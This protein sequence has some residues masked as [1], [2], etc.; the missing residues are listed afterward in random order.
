MAS[1]RG[2]HSARLRGRHSGTAGWRLG[3]LAVIALLVV[4]LPSTAATAIA[5]T[6]P[7]SYTNPLRPQTAEGAAVD[8]CPDPSVIRGRGAHAGRWFMYCTNASLPAGDGSAR[9]TLVSL[10]M[11]ASRDMVSWRSEGAAISRPSWAAPETYLWAPDIVYSRAHRRYYLTYTVTDTVD[12]MS[13]EPGCTKDSAIGVA[14]ST[15]PLGPWRHAREPVVR[16]RRAGPGCSFALTIDSDVLGDVVRTRGVLFFGGYRG[17]IQAQRIRLYPYRIALTGARQAITTHR[18]EAANVVARGGYYYLFVSAGL[19]CNHAL[20]GY[21]VFAGRATDPLGPYVDAHGNR[22]LASRTGGTPVLASSG[23]RWVG[24]GHNSV[25]R[26]FAG[27]WWTMYHAIDL[28]TPGFDRE[29]GSTRRV[30]MLDPVDWIG[31]WPSV[32]AG[33]G[34]STTP[35][36]GPAARSGQQSGYRPSWLAHDPPGSAVLEPS[37]EFGDSNLHPRWTWVREPASD[38]YE[39]SGGSLRVGTSAEA[40]TGDR[41]A[42]VLTTPAPDGDFVVETAVRLGTSSGPV[43]DHLRVG[44]VMYADDDRYVSLF[45]STPGILQTTEF[46]KYVSSVDPRV[47]NHGAMSVGPPGDVT[48]LRLVRRLVDGH[49]TFTAYTQQDG[50]PWVR[51]G[52][53]RHDSPGSP[54]RIGLTAHGAAGYTATF[55]YVR[56]RT[57]G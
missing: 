54:P 12:S 37:D 47:P 29:P 51:G 38:T 36:P 31:G 6:A 28:L 35:M 2:T 41:R 33:R 45:V 44:L 32:R 43:P 20:S 57:L 56:T 39:L 49:E 8:T 26:D 11:L 50:N 3:W 1:T 15:S 40:L 9:R 22:L 14:T 24:P 16:P 4:A 7:P 48:R 18:Y 21:G 34:A 19:C 42:P 17:G 27:Q 55:D 10:P 25:F 23:N 30:V 53:W 5:G 46:G 13:G 52:T